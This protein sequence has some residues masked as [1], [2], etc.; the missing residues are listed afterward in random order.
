[1]AVA[2]IVGTVEVLIGE[3]VDA[4][5]GFVKAGKAEGGREGGATV[6]IGHVLPVTGDKMTVVDHV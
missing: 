6:G 1:M 5:F 4:G 2:L 3:W